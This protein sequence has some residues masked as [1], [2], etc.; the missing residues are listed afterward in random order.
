MT[1]GTWR[2][3]FLAVLL[4]AIVTLIPRLVF[5][6]ADPPWDFQT[7]FLADEGAWAHN[8]RQHV[9]FGR[10]IMDE[11]N[12]GLFAAPLYSL[13]LELLYRFIGIGLTQ[14]RLLSA[15]SGFLS[16]LLWY[17]ALRARLPIRRALTV[18]L[19][20][21]L[22][23][24]MLSNNRAAFTESFQ[25]LFISATV[26]VMFHAWR[27][28]EWAIA[29]GTCFVLSLLVKPSAGLI[30]L[31]F[32]VFWM[33]H[34][35]LSRRQAIAPSFSFRQPILFTVSA[36]VAAVIV[37]LVLVVPNWDGVAHQLGISLRSVYTRVGVAEGF[38]IPLFGW[39]AFGL[40]A[41]LFF[42]QCGVLLLTVLIFAAA[43]LGRAVNHPVEIEELFCWVWLT[44]GLVFLAI[45]QYQ[46]DRR[47][48][49][50]M[51]PVTYLAVTAVM[52]GGLRIP[53]RPGLMGRRQWWRSALIGGLLGGIPGIYWQHFLRLDLLRRF[54]ELFANEIAAGAAIWG[55]A[56]LAGVAIGLLLARRLPL[57]PI[58]LP[59]YLFVGLFLVYDPLRFGYYLAR[60]RF[61]IP[62]A[63][64]EIAALTRDWNRRDQVIVGTQADAFALGSELFSFSIRMRASTGAYLN[65]DGWE[66]F[67]PSMAVVIAP[68]GMAPT[69]PEQRYVLN[70]ALRR[71]FVVM[72]R[73]PT[74]FNRKGR[75]TYEATVYVRPGLLSIPP[76]L[77]KGS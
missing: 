67:Q 1:R 22:S 6:G 10:W 46:P 69:E 33:V 50:L 35:Y 2:R 5:L 23:Y 53:G 43:R 51:P 63:N 39:K 59:A 21:G 19:V 61:S 11:N 49:L 72:G 30:G 36:L 8:A 14:T 66:R 75:V 70:E 44:V 41:N 45:Q 3:E 38:R 60:P 20:L 17:V 28:P 4:I 64:R 25:L 16:C 13:A 68:P 31:V 65:L 55:A 77:V 32:L 24:F 26:A 54:P 56:I 15:V 74:R 73:Y 9:L 7:G 29:G 76:S 58:V 27:R 47:F 71:G 40:S 48:L 12:P 37:I 34:W 57:G 52:T 62:A 42:F 18:S